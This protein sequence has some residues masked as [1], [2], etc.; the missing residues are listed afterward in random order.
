MTYKSFFQAKSGEVSAKLQ[1]FAS[2][3]TFKNYFHLIDTKNQGYVELEEI[4]L[5]FE[6]IIKSIWVSMGL[7]SS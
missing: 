4:R 6:N 5:F 7:F 1:Y 3:E 2:E